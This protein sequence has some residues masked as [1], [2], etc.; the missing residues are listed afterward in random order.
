MENVEC[1]MNFGLTRQEANLYV[2]LVLEGELNGYEAAKK[3]A[4]PGP[5][6]TMRWQDLWKKGP[7]ICPRKTL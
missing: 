3:A 5:T 6:P 2:L 4:S 7:P 1:L